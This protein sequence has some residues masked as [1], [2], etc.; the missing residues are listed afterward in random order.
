MVQKTAAGSYRTEY[1]LMAI[2]DKLEMNAYAYGYTPMTG[3]PT[4]HIT[5]E[6]EAKTL[7]TADRIAVVKYLAGE[8]ALGASADEMLF[9]ALMT[10]QLE[11]ADALMEM[12]VDL[13]KNLPVFYDGWTEERV[14][15]ETITT[16]KQ[17]VYWSYYTSLFT[18][19]APA[20]QLPVLERLVKLTKA[21][22]KQLLISQKLFDELEWTDAALAFVLQNADI[23]KVNQKK[24]L[25]RAVTEGYFLCLS[26][27]AESG[28]LAQAAKRENLIEFARSNQKTEAL[29][30]L[31]D[32]KN[33]TVDIAAEEE[34][35][36][37]ETFDKYSSDKGKLVAVTYGDKNSDGTYSKYKTFLLNYNSY[38]VRVVYEGTTYTI[39][40]GGYIVLEYDQT[41]G[42]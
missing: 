19:L 13:N 8:K 26:I 9:L 11:I 31:L 27:M 25:E 5:E 1:Y 4:L 7:P 23:P 12:G 20:V 17:S 42:G 36:E 38:S 2:P 34:K 32:F 22:D 3:I 39:P 16:G 33:R 30:W 35:E 28:W 10:G 18:K 14:Y 24:A 37:D 21:A 6:Q 41:N 15:L 29:A 40:S